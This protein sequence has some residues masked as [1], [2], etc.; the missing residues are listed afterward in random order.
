MALPTLEWEFRIRDKVL[1]DLVLNEDVFIN[2]YCSLFVLESAGGSLCPY[3]AFSNGK[4]LLYSGA[5]WKLTVVI[6][7]EDCKGGPAYV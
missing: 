4:G 6:L 1:F 2:T 7:I 3:G 5:F